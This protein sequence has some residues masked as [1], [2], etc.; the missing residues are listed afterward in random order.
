MQRELTNREREWVIRTGNPYAKLSV[1][2]NEEESFTTKDS[3]HCTDKEPIPC[4]PSSSVAALPF[5]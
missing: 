2:E 5:R 1:L 3:Q 4:P